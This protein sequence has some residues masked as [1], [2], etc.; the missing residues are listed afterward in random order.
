MNN[1]VFWIKNKYVGLFKISSGGMGEV[2]AGKSI[3][4]QGFHTNIA[5]KRLL[6]YQ[7]NK[8]NYLRALFDEATTLQHLS[9]SP[10]LVRIIDLCV[11]K[12]RPNIIMEYIDGPEL[13]DILDQLEK[14]EIQLPLRLTLY[15]INEISKGLT[16]VHNAIHSETGKA[17]NII[18]RDISPSNILISSQGHIKIT[19]FGI[20]K[21]TLQSNATMFGEIKGKFKYMSPEQASGKTL[22]F[23]TDYFSLGLT[24]YECLLGRAAYQT[25][26]E[27]GMIANAQKARIHYPDHLCNPLQDILK[28]LLSKNPEDRY[29]NL[30]AFRKDLGEVSLYYDGMGTSDEL[31]IFLEELQNHSWIRAKEFRHQLNQSTDITNKQSRIDDNLNLE[32]IVYQEKP[33]FKILLW[34]IFLLI[35]GSAIIYQFLKNKE[36]IIADNV[37]PPKQVII[38]EKKQQPPKVTA[39]TYGQLTIRSSET[40]SKINIQYGKKKIEMISPAHIN[41]LPLNTGI[42][43]IVSKDG[44]YTKNTVI[45]LKQDHPKKDI[46]VALQAIP[47]AYVRFTSQPSAIVEIP[48]LKRDY[49]SPSPLIP[50]KPGKYTIIYKSELISQRAQTVLDASNGGEFICFANLQVNMITRLP[51][52]KQIVASCQLQ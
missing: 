10:N 49:D 16:H 18:H 23:Q 51:T 31:H 24:F 1:H 34:G 42:K 5:I 11:E 43:I 50:L 47:N 14:K 45:Y 27:A 22:T 28:K 46:T 13:H 32:T 19:D 36:K 3:G 7:E 33:Y 52:G 12:G 26:T 21:S 35:I 4:D 30:D 37:K 9:H 8:E 2:W 41:M 15:I 25:D 44:F 17:L 39:I 6:Q 29:T 40:N 38:P 20:A 48:E